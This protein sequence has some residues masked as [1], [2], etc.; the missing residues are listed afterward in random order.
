MGHLMTKTF[1]PRIGIHISIAGGL[2]NAIKRAE[3][4]RCDC[5]QIFARNPRG[6]AARELSGTGFP[7]ADFY[8][9]VATAS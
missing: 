8:P 6:W 7:L 4:L 3:A 5:L 9:D 2:P 1:V